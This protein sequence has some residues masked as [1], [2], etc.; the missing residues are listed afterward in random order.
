MP[1]SLGKTFI[2]LICKK[3][4]PNFVTYLIKSCPTKILPNHLKLV[5]PHFIGREQSGFVASHSLFDNILA[6]KRLLIPL[7]RIS[8]APLG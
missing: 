5:L 3:D 8:D 4:N 6:L 2:V 1:N 7:G